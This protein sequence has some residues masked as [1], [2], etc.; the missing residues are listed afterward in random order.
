MGEPLVGP[1]HLEPV[2][3]PRRS[4]RVL[5]GVGN[6]IGDGLENL[7]VRSDQWITNHAA[8][9]RHGVGLLHR[10]QPHGRHDLSQNLRLHD[11]LLRIE[12]S[13]SFHLFFPFCFPLK[14]EFFPSPSWRWAVAPS[15]PWRIRGVPVSAAL[16]GAGS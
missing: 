14:A 5:L 15:P 13:N 16:K 1:L 11:L 9:H 3:T 6:N 7:L 8:D 10:V 2:A 4:T 12:I